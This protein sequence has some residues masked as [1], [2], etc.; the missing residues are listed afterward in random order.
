MMKK[1]TRN[2]SFL[3]GWINL[4]IPRK[5][6]ATNLSFNYPKCCS[7]PS[8]LNQN[9]FL[10]IFTCIPRAIII[11]IRT[12]SYCRKQQWRLQTSFSSFIWFFFSFFLHIALFQLDKNLLILFRFRQSQILYY[13]VHSKKLYHVA[14]ITK[15]FW[16]VISFLIFQ[17]YSN[18][19]TLFLQIYSIQH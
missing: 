3:G 19:W 5:Y 12:V 6:S 2:T 8:K 17:F 10:L 15:I 11:K 7:R 9:C 14:N 4:L 13:I 16:I 18:K 1:S